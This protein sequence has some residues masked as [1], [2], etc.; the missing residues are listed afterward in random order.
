M[1]TLLVM[2]ALAAASVACADDP[3]KSDPPAD[4][5]AAQV[6]AVFKGLDETQEKLGAEFKAA[7]DPEVKSKLRKQFAEA[8]QAAADKLLKLAQAKPDDEPAFTALGFVLGNGDTAAAADL[9]AKH[10]LGR[11]QLAGLLPQVADD[12]SPAV[13]GLLRAAVDKSPLPAVKAAAIM[14]L[15]SNLAEQADRGNAKAAAEAEPLLERAV[16]EFGD[17]RWEDGKVK[18][19]AEQLLFV[20]RNLSVGK[21][22]PEFASKD[23]DG[24]PAKLSDLKGKV[25]VLDIWA[26]WCGPCRQMIPHE[27]EL[28]KKLAGKPFALVSVSADNKKEDLTDFLKGEPMPWTHWW[29]GD[30]PNLKTWN[31]KYFPTIYVIDAKGVIRYKGVR[32]KAMDEAVETLVKEAEAGK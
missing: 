20:L 32:G 7:K 4:P 14:A 15:A 29:E 2:T 19:A 9:L 16:K 25:V 17:Q 13:A 23:L 5:R 21:P 10:H 24:N 31:V 11:E 22:A 30:G 28:V 18:A 12:P 1:R 8:M 3:K 6:Q 27:R 26:T